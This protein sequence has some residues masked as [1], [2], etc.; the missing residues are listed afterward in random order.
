M[1]AGARSFNLNVK[2][3][4]ERNSLVILKREGERRD[5]LVVEIE[6]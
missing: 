5:S 1:T 3:V 2:W 6:L 4:G